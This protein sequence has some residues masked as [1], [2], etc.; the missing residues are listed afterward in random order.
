M[1][2]RALKVLILLAVLSILP[3]RAATLTED[4][5]CNSIG[6]KKHLLH[7][8]FNLVE[9]RVQYFQ[10]LKNLGLPQ[11]LALPSIEIVSDLLGMTLKLPLA[12]IVGDLRTEMNIE[13]K[14]F[15]VTEF[16]E[17]SHGKK[18]KKIAVGMDLS[19][20]FNWVSQD[21]QEVERFSLVLRFATDKAF[22]SVKKMELV[23]LRSYTSDR[24]HNLE[25]TE[26]IGTYELEEIQYQ[27][28]IYPGD[29]E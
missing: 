9:S 21:G 7:Y 27:L 8:R 16:E 5:A 10:Q 3:A 4:P 1:N 25:S 15:S 14:N 29:E 23:V 17:V 26:E 6:A 11:Q 20:R 19:D 28:P 12:N 22:K 2:R 13:T 24:Y 18:V